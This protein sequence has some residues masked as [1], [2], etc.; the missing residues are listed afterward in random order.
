MIPGGSVRDGGA[1]RFALKI[2][3]TIIAEGTEGDMPRRS[4][5]APEQY[6]THT[7]QEFVESSPLNRLPLD[8]ERLIF[9]QPLVGFAD[10]DD[11]L[12]A[13]YKSIIGDFHVTPRQAYRHAAEGVA[14]TSPSSLSV[15]S[16][17]LPISQL[18][19]EGNRQQT[20][21]PTEAWAQTRWYGEQLNDGVRDH[22]V[23]VLQETGYIAIAPPRSDL[24]HVYYDDIGTPPA[25]TWSERHTAFAAGLGTFSLSD[26]FI[27]P[28]GIAMRCGS[29]VTDLAMTPTPRTYETHYDNCLLMAK[30]T[31]GTCIDRCPGGAITENG[32]DKLKCRVYMKSIDYLKE[33]FGTE[34]FGC[35]LCQTAVPCEDCIPKA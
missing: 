24:F 21:E 14:E 29:V 12:F 8:R 33:R 16:W 7:I 10:G 31:C 4:I 13:E 15:I 9:G 3:R 25:S 1:A 11:P 28:K 5:D 17:I 6:V 18:T 26:G 23:A 27:T 35:G 34:I 22:V 19:R 30:G 32:H 2:D 20:L